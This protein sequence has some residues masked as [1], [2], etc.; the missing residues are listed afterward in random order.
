VKRARG[1]G[2][3]EEREER[4]ERS[5]VEREGRGERREVNIDR[6]CF[7]YA[8]LLRLLEQRYERSEVRGVR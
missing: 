4:G 8:C 5:E 1:Q 7:D 2:R 6:V 3:E